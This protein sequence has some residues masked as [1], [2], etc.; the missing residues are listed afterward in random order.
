[1]SM[2]PYMTAYS[3]AYFDHDTIYDNDGIKRLTSLGW[4]LKIQGRIQGG[5][6]SPLPNTG[7]DPGGELHKE[8]EKRC[9]HVRELAAF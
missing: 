7:A 9:A 1:M 6:A 4:V 3:E 2:I 8:G 5:E